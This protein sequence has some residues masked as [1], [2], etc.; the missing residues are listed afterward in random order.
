MK[1]SK[2]QMAEHRDQIIESAARQFRESGFD[3]ISVSDVMKEAGLTHGGFYGHFDSKEELMALA[4][5]RAVHKSVSKYAKIIEGA[6]QKPLMT[7][8]ESYLS[9]RHQAHPET[10]CLFAAVGSELARQPSSVKHAV[11]Q[12]E[13]KLLELI[14][15]I[16]PGRTKAAKRRR[17]I[18]VFAELVGAMIL[19]RCVPDPELSKEILATVSDS[20]AAG[21]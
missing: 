8:V 11:M 9:S 10:G 15:R 5:Q 21:Q 1:V 12:E 6:P 4:S 19:A 2:L 16:V 17:A 18:A 20:V 13:A 7:L 14:A 3:G